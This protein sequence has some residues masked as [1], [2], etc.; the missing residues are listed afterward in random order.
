MNGEIAQV[1][2]NLGIKI[3]EKFVGTARLHYKS[4]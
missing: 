3:N 4:E 2:N 1:T